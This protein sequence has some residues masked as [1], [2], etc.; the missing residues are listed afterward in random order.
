MA[1]TGPVNIDLLSEDELRDLHHRI[2]ERLRM[3][4][5]LRTHGVMMQFSIGDR[6]SFTSDG[7]EMSGIITRYNRKTVTVIVDGGHHWTV[8]PGLLMQEQPS[9][10]KQAERPRDA[11]RSQPSVSVAPLLRIAGQSQGGAMR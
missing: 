8:S 2:V 3:I 9:G 11:G 4:Q 1:R 6:V 5:Q 10:P 7:R